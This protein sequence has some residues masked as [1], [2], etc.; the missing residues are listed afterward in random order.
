MRA[1]LLLKRIEAKTSEGVGMVGKALG[2]KFERGSLEDIEQRITDINAS[3]SQLDRDKEAITVAFAQD[4][5]EKHGVML[6]NQQAQ[7]I[8]YSVNGEI[9]IDATVVL[10][11]LTEVERRLAEVMSQKVGAEAQRDYIGVASATRLI[12]AR[13]LQ[14][15]LDQYDNWLPE[16][17]GMREETQRLLAQ[18]KTDAAR[19]SQES[20]RM[21]YA[22]NIRLQE[23]ILTVIDKYSD[24][25]M[26]R[27][28]LTADALALAEERAAA[29]INTLQT[30]DTAA[31]LSAII[32]NSTAD[33]DKIIEIQ[34]PEMEQFDPAD[35]DEMLDISRK[36][37]S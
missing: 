14:R 4:M 29:A 5:N 19:A 7:A 30:L 23:R 35:F 2:R 16:L 25:L 6:S 18:T 20:V 28:Q 8:L 22:N 12:Y 10:S 15:H 33:Y 21:T 36:L 32:A 24:M 13:L 11:A 26:R 1:E 17:T 37:T 3:L 31:G 27:R 9:L 34:L